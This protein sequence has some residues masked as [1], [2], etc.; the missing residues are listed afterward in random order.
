MAK[1]ETGDSNQWRGEA[2]ALG[3]RLLTFGVLVASA[4]I[5]LA[6]LALW[7][8]LHYLAVAVLERVG[9]LGHFNDLLLVIMQVIF[10]VSTLI[11]VVTYTARDLFLTIRRIWSL[12]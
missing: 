7:A 1:T 9:R 5:D 12:K 8:V 6:F 4:I 3:R 10:D 11:V 2:R